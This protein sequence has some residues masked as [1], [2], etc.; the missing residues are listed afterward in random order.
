[1]NIILKEVESKKD[2]K[3]F[4]DFQFELYKNNPFWVPPLKKEEHFLLDRGKNP[5]F[6]FCET[7]YWLAYK[8]GEVVGRIAGIINHKFNEK[9]NKKIVRFGWIDFVN[10]EEV[11]KK[12]LNAVEDW[13]KE[14]GMNEERLFIKEIRVDG[15]PMLKR[16]TPR[17]QG[18]ATPIHKHT[19]HITITLHEGKKS[20]QSRF[21]TAK[22]EQKEEKTD[23]AVGEVSAAS[24]SAE[25][26][27]HDP[28]T[29]PSLK[30]AKK[31]APTPKEAKKK[32][33]SKLFRRKSV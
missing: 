3:R 25:K 22:P 12:L 19:S 28:E 7:K 1:M 33:P 23:K 5:A 32:S 30:E 21:V 4:V 18:R 10:D 27:S 20:V 14:K 9:F 11:S 16:W 17:A 26:H 29:T 6:D 15:G 13:A 31:E 2:L 24:Q 8:D